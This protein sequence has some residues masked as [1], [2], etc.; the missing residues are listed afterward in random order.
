M[1]DAEIAE[2]LERAFRDDFGCAVAVVTAETW[3]GLPLEPRFRFGYMP[4]V[5]ITNAGDSFVI[6]VSAELI[7]RVTGDLDEFLLDQYLTAVEAFVGAHLMDP[8]ESVDETIKRVEDQLYEQA[9]E[10]LALMSQVEA[11]AIDA[12]IVSRLS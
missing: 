6:S 11:N 10:A 4:P 9:P 3:Q 1:R 2:R 12:G 8:A 5:A 7:D